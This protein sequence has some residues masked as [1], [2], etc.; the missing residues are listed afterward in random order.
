MNLTRSLGVEMIEIPDVVGQSWADARPQL[1]EAGFDLSY[2]G[3][4][5]LLPGTFIVSQLTPGGG[6]SAPK[7]STVKINFS[8]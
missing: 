4:A 5:D 1:D 8:S 7:G 3:V 6:T 2:N